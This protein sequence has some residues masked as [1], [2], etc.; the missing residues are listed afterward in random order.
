MRQILVD[1]TRIAEFDLKTGI[2]RVTCAVLAH[3]LHKPPP[4]CRVEPVYRPGDGHRY[5]YARAF[6]GSFLE[7]GGVGLEDA[8]MHIAPGDIFL[9]LDLDPR[10]AE[11]GHDFLRYHAH[12]GLRVIIV[13]YDL[14]LARQTDWFPREGA[15]IFQAWLRRTAEIAH[16]FACISQ[17]TAD[18]LTD[19]LATAGSSRQLDIGYFH[20]GADMEGT[21]PSRSASEKTA[22]MLAPIED[23]TCLLMVGTLEPRKGY[24]QALDG[25]ERLWAQGEDAVLVIVGKQGWMVESLVKRLRRHPGGRAAS[26]VA[27]RRRRRHP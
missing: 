16:G 19:W 27:R 6:T 25:M 4:G 13:V 26:V 8:P 15:S 11:R 2:Q 9:A 3:L 22:A 12:R 20:L 1:V 17:T 7:L 14:L 24:R 23:R 21:R 10:V 18:D 5:H